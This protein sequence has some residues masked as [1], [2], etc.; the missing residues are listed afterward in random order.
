MATTRFRFRASSVSGKQGT[1][2]IQVIHKRVARQVSTQY[3]LY[4]DEWDT[5]SQSVVIPKDT[6]SNRSPYLHAVQEALQH[7]T[8]RLQRIIL[9]LD[10]SRKEYHA[11]DVVKRFLKKEPSNEF[12]VFAESLIGQKRKEG[13]LSLATKYQSSLNS[14][15]RF[16]NGRL[17]TFDDMD[18]SL[19]LSYESYLKKLGRCPNT[20]SFYMRNLRAIYNQAVEQG[21]TPQNHPFAR[22]YTGIAKTMKR[23][24]N[25]EEVQKI[26]AKEL[27]PDSAD[28]FSRD[29]FLFSLYT[30]GM[31]LTD[32]AHLKKSDLQGDYLSYCRQ[33]TGQRINIR[34]EPC[35]QQLVDKYKNDDSPYLFPLITRPG[36]DEAR[37]YQN[38]IHLINQH[39]KKLGE[40]LGLSSNLTSYVARH[41]WASIA[42]SQN[43]PVAAIS[44][45]MGH[46]TERTTRIYLKS[47]ENTLVDCANQKVLSAIA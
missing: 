25:I 5:D 43:V 22:V 23:A 3:K 27:P 32:I 33:K 11:K 13:H 42:K 36:E 40:A 30:C 1:L 12:A 19:M 20:T 31:S 29:I 18:S 4:P 15:N 46:T 26:K 37:Q 24:V 8:S 45:A 21:L 17:L 39:L 16:L 10:H 44:E 34:W 28:E 47:F 35:M 6:S 2:F 9:A 41:S 7:D 14:L 38:Q